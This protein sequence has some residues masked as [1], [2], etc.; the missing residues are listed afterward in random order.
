MAVPPWL[1]QALSE[2]TQFTCFKEISSA[3]HALEGA[4]LFLNSETGPQ[5]ISKRSAPP[6]DATAPPQRHLFGAGP[7]PSKA[8]SRTPRSLSSWTGQG[9]HSGDGWQARC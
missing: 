7:A 3:S 4:L 6:A 2:N 8:L 5:L 1:Q 9:T